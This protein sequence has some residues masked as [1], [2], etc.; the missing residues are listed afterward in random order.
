MFVIIWNNKPI[1]SFFYSF[2]H[3]SNLNSPIVQSFYSLLPANLLSKQLYPLQ[4][5]ND[6]KN[7]LWRIL[8]VTANKQDWEQRDLFLQNIIKDSIIFPFTQLS[9]RKQWATQRALATSVVARKAILLDP[10]RFLRISSLSKRNPMQDLVISVNS[11]KHI[12]HIDLKI[13]LQNALPSYLLLLCTWLE[14]FKEKNTDKHVFSK[15]HWCR[16]EQEYQ[17]FLQ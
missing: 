8:K 13:N 12:C 15:A 11:Y 2:S 10:I 7:I 17:S 14:I 16:D 9:T 6:S 1:L 5:I 4:I 3:S